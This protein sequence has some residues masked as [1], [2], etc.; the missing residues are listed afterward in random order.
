MPILTLIVIL[1]IHFRGEDDLHK[2]QQ[3]SYRIKRYLKWRFGDFSRI[4]RPHELLFFIGLCL[5]S[6]ISAPWVKIIGLL[7]ML[8]DTYFFWLIKTAYPVKK[9]LVYTA[10]VKRLKA[11]KTFL[12]A[13]L[14][15]VSFY[16][17]TRLFIIGLTYFI[18]F[19]YTFMA[20]VI[21]MPLEHYINE[22]YYKDAQIEL[23]K[24]PHLNV[25]G[26]TGSYGKTSTKNVINTM[27]SKDF[28]VLMTPESFNTKMGLTRTLR[29]GLK[30]IHQ[31][32]IAEMGA[33]EVGDIKEL[34]DFVHPTMAIIT[35]IGP[36][37][38]ESFITLENVIKTKGEL[39]QAIPSGGTLFLNC[40]DENIMKLP[41]REDVTIY[42]YAVGDKASSPEAHDLN[43]YI[44]KLKLRS[45]GAS[46][47]LCYNT[48][49]NGTGSIDL[50][51]KL[52]GRHNLS[53][54]VAACAVA[55]HL[56]V[57]IPRLPVL[58]SS[59]QPV[60]HR[61]SHRLIAD[62]YTLL[63]DAFN[64]N[65]VGSKMALEVLEHY[66][67]KKKIIITPGMIELG[68]QG[69]SLNHA[70]GEAI[71]KVCDVVILVGPKLTVPIQE[72]LKAQK[73]PDSNCYI[74]KSIHDAYAV[75]NDI[76][77]EGD[78]VLIENDLPDAFNEALL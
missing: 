38:L 35:S 66:E 31:V 70:F 59:I 36:Q 65:P 42:R 49:K 74:V 57:E 5:A 32:F 10:R 37:H 71:A 41:V 8:V 69:N 24:A 30:P 58:V 2:F 55:L 50:T 51:T 64:S 4:I 26:I 19:I 39:F 14:A 56:G 68:D 11:T 60:E 29:E 62:K 27:L 78:V 13:A 61:L 43:V 33:K 7:M 75:L 54:I 73:Y 48:E 52:L 40:D 22:S 21:N 3:N 9:A 77:D 53:N 76:V 72:G 63:D 6:F 17:P 15:V 28:N 12:L 1:L 47:T 18:S 46:F 25:L 45:S 20:A 16:I 23:S 67:G 44:K 34:C